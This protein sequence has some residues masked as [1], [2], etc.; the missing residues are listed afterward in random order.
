MTDI[1][2]SYA[3]FPAVTGSTT[4]LDLVR[5]I[6]G[7]GVISII[8]LFRTAAKRFEITIRPLETTIGKLYAS[9]S[10]IEHAQI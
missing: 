8:T 5:A 10:N 2:K 6:S 9:F 3:S 4:W 7:V 1:L